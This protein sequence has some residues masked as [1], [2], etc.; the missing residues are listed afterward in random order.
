M[1][2]MHW[3]KYGEKRHTWDNLT[4]I[5]RVSQANIQ[6][7]NRYIILRKANFAIHLRVYNLYRYIELTFRLIHKHILL[8][9]YE[10]RVI[11]RKW[12]NV[13]IC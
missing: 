3:V 4:S 10:N 5:L 9:D 2:S 6:A 1:K 13:Q 7:F 8:V 11:H 12:Q